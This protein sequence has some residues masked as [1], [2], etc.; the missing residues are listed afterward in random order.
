MAA[1]RLAGATV[2]VGAATTSVNTPLVAVNGPVPVLLSVAVTVKLKEPPAVGAPDKVPLLASERP[3]G[4]L[5]ELTV[6]E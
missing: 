2:I 5:P 6:Y 1:V 4:R 3:A